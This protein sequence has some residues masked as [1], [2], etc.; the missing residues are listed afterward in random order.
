[1]VGKLHLRTEQPVYAVEMMLSWRV[2]KGKEE[3]E[4][5][6]K[7]NKQNK[8]KQTK[9]KPPNQTNKHTKDKDY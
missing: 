1:M 5:T 8:K 7:Q 3:E 4:K 2:L 6:K 9:K